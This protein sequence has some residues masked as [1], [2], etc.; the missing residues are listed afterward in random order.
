MLPSDGVC[1]HECTRILCA[2]CGHLVLTYLVRC[3][4][5]KRVSLVM[6]IVTFPTVVKK[7]QT[8]SGT[9]FKLVKEFVQVFFVVFFVLCS[10]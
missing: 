6:V 3:A 1:V 5:D 2:D 4:R 10:L 9:I 8:T 7:T